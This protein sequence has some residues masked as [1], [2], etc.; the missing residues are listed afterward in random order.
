[1]IDPTAC[2]SALESR[3]SGGTSGSSSREILSEYLVPLAPGFMATE[4]G[5][6]TMKPFEVRPELALARIIPI[7]QG[8]D[9]S[10]GNPGHTR[11]SFDGSSKWQLADGGVTFV[12]TYRK[13]T[14]DTSHRT[15]VEDQIP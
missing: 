7:R 5:P 10:Q 15:G 1:M 8:G 13:R 12:V 3:F 11:Q 2:R 6:F 4:S 14:R 9:S